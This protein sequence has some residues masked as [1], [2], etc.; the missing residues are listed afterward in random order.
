MVEPATRLLVID[1]VHLG[2]PVSK[3]RARVTEHGAYTPT[4]TRDAEESW[5]WLLR[6]SCPEFTNA[7]HDFDYRLELG[8]YTATWRR[9]DLDNLVKLVSDACNGLVY[10]DDRQVTEINATLVRADPNPRT[11][12]MVF[13]LPPRRK[14][15]SRG[16]RR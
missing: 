1:V 12:L 15:N 4:K 16:Q 5:Q 2:D 6:T 14:A 11:H 3:A 13:R 7:D 9:C 8:F 10:A